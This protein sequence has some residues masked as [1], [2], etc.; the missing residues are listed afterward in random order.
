MELE[1]YIYSYYG[2]DL[3]SILGTLNGYYSVDV[4]IWKEEEIE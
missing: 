1:Y 3:H 2:Q 4:A